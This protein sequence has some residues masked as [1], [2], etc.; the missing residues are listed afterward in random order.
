MLNSRYFIFKFK[1]KF[2]LQ[3]AKKLFQGHKTKN[4]ANMYILECPLQISD[5]RRP[6]HIQANY[7]ADGFPAFSA[8]NRFCDL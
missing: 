8:G 7:G 3:L 1:R 2:A 5:S 4:V 6:I